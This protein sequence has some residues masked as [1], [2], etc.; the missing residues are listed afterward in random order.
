MSTSF[1]S[2]AAMLKQRI[3]STPD[4][5]AFYYPDSADEWQ[6]LRWSDV[7]QRTEAI[8]AGLHVLGLGLEERCSIL[9]N[10]RI[11]WILVDLGILC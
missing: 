5:D 7:G 2:V 11:E 6:T 9:C 1:P 10:T 3:Q 4:A 8:A